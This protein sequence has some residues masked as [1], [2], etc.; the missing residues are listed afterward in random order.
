MS[1]TRPAPRT[2]WHGAAAAGVLT[3][4]LG[5]LAGCGDP[6]P[7]IISGSPQGASAS[8]SLAPS[9]DSPASS[10]AS[11]PATST[12]PSETA[13][14][15]YI[16]YAGGEDPGPFIANSTQVAKLKGAPDD[17]KNFI[18]RVADDLQE[19]SSC[20]ADVGVTV[21]DVRSDGFASGAI[22]DCGGYQ[23]LWAKVG[24]EWKEIAGTQDIWTCSLLKEY[25]V[26]SDVAGNQCYVP[27]QSDLQKYRQK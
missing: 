18:G 7:E 19:Q 1:S 3:V 24:Q 2:L 6:G 27:G 25:A 12:S 17:F 21:F 14:P 16:R 20:Q 22:S 8:E 13:K 26:P 4:T 23:A 15:E 5:A 10:P 9:G 11:S